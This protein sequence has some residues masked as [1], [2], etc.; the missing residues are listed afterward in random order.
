MFYFDK[1]PYGLKVRSVYRCVA[2][3]AVCSNMGQ[4]LAG[5]TNMASWD[6][7]NQRAYKGG[8]MYQ[9]E[10]KRTVGRLVAD[11]LTYH[12]S[13]ANIVD[14]QLYRGKCLEKM[15]QQR[16]RLCF[17]LQTTK[18]QQLDWT[19]LKLSNPE[20]WFIPCQVLTSNH[21]SVCVCNFACTPHQKLVKRNLGFDL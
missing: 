14:E 19:N 5:W 8:P 16:S 9:R 15:S 21:R 11:V 17:K 13:L 2:N 12:S 1:R 6:M 20:I 4:I 7:S 10:D 18:Q 3:T